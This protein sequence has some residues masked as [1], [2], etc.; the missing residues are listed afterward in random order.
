M[1]TVLGQAVSSDKYTTVPITVGSQVVG[2][3]AL[4]LPKNQSGG[5]VNGQVVSLDTHQ[6]VVKVSA[7]L[8]QIADNGDIPLPSADV[9]LG[10][11]SASAD[12]L[13][14][15]GGVDLGMS[16]SLSFDA[17]VMVTLSFDQMVT[18]RI[19]ATT[20]AASKTV[21][22]DLDDGADLVFQGQAGRL[23]SRTF[24]MGVDSLLTNRTSI[25]VD[26][27]LDIQGGCFSMRVPTVV[28][29]S[30]CVMSQNLRTTDLVSE[31]VYDESF[32]L[33]GFNTVTFT[34]AVPEPETWAMLLAGLSLMGTVARRRRSS[35][36]FIA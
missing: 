10:V 21:T 34:T 18:M 1:A 29:S 35:T 11:A 7:D 36:H 6:S 24:S 31:T 19:G 32:A 5:M 22:F 12:S 20:Y 14:M 17:N 16:Q 9:N 27:F 30:D 26:P 23:V 25:S 3:V 4:T 28:N 8:A 13:Y 15:K 33:K 2:D